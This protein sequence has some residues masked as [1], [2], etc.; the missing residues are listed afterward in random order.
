[1]NMVRHAGTKHGLRSSAI[2]IASA[3]VVLALAANASRGQEVPPA[4]KDPSAKPRPAET[5]SGSSS[6]RKAEIQRAI[7][8]LGSS[9][10]A[11]RERASRALWN[12]G[13]EAEPALEKAVRETDDFE[14]VYRARQ[15]LQSFQVG[16]YADTPAEIVALIGQFRM[17]NFNMKQVVV[18]RLKAKGKT[19]LLRRLIAKETNPN[20]REQLNQFLA[21]PVRRATPTPMLPVPRSARFRAC[22]CGGACPG[23]AAPAGP[24]RLRR[25]RTAASRRRAA[26]NRC[27]TTPLCC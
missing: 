16:I 25:G 17:G 27:G 10:F 21:I 8:D 20:V 6:A 13:A 15:I 4:G 22:R 24:A 7:A 1:M 5:S 23:S 19:D 26:T 12:A 9:D 14:V 18:Q 11:V 2:G 3:V